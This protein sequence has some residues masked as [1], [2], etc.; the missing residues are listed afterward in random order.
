MRDQRGG[1]N[2]RMRLLAL[3]LALLLA[4]PLTALVLQGAVRVLS[5]AGERL[6][7]AP[8]GRLALGCAIV[9]HQSRTTLG[10]SPVGTGGGPNVRSDDAAA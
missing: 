4:G 9:D 5:A 3:V 10:Y 1:P 6:G 7:D 8:G 2:R